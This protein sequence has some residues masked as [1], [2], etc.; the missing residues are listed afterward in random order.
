MTT[1]WPKRD[2]EGRHVSD[3]Q[4]HKASETLPV[5]DENDPKFDGN[6]FECDVEV[7][8]VRGVEQCQFYACWSN[9]MNYDGIPY[10]ITEFDCERKVIEWRY[11]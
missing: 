3:L 2:E 11:I 8:T 1:F 5:N 9:E 4:W 7:R 6:W 10:L